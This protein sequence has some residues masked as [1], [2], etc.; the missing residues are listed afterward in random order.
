MFCCVFPQLGDSVGLCLLPNLRHFQPLF[1]QILSH[2]LSFSSHR[3]SKDKKVGSFVIISTG[4][5]GSVC[6]FFWA[7]ILCCSGWMN[8][9]APSSNSG[10]VFC[11]LYFTIEPIY[12]VFA[13]CIFHF[14]NLYF[15]NSK[16]CFIS[17]IFHV[18]L[19]FQENSYLFV[20]LFYDGCFIILVR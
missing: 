9:I 12:W 10:S 15:L 5:W 11:H 8:S 17:K 13:C 1:L 14:Y 19:S 7:Y 3:D 16:F 6:L 4:H 2:C 20:K 18:S